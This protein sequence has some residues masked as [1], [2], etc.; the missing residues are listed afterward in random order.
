MCW[1]IYTLAYL[2]RNN[3]S[4]AITALETSLNINKMSVAMLGTL[5]YWCYAGGKL[6]SGYFGDYVNNE[7]LLLGATLVSGLSNILMGFVTE[8][9]LLMVVWSINGFAQSALWCNMIRIISRWFEQEAQGRLVIWLSTSMIMGSLM[10]YLGCGLLIQ[11]LPY[12]FSFILPGVLLILAGLVWMLLGGN[13]AKSE[14]FIVGKNETAIQGPE[15]PSGSIGTF[16]LSSGLLLITVACLAQGMVKDSIGLWGPVMLEETFNIP[17]GTSA[18]MLWMLPLFNFVGIMAIGFLRKHRFKDEPLAAIFM[19]ASLACLQVMRMTENQWV[20]IISLCMLS[21]LMYGVNILLL[22]LYPLRFVAQGRV[23]FVSGFLD[24]S[25]YVAAGLGSMI[26]ASVLDGGHGWSPVYLLWML[27]TVL[28]LGFL[29][30]IVHLRKRKEP[31]S[32]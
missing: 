11:V 29:M 2:G 19:I 12:Q 5:F 27:M 3:L 8:T 21:A 32:R 9:W 25:A 10:A 30:L 31:R 15:K 23:S 17:A 22:T 13:D 20:Y 16:I 24:A 28:S 26:L 14:G 1:I 4:V 7:Y 18:A 6:V